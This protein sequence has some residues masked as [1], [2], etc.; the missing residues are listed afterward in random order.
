MPTGFDAFSNSWS[1]GTSSPY[2]RA[3]IGFIFSSFILNTPV[4][5][6]VSLI[7]L[8]NLGQ[9]ID[10]AAGAISK[11]GDGI[12]HLIALGDKGYNVVEARI[13]HNRLVN[14]DAKLFYII[15]Y[16]ERII[17]SLREYAEESRRH[18]NG[19]DRTYELEEELQHDWPLVLT[20]L[21]DILDQTRDLL[22]RVRVERSDF[23]LEPAYGEMLSALST[24]VGLLDKLIREGPP[25]SKEQVDELDIVCDK[26]E[27]LREATAGATAQMSAYIKSIGQQ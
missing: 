3:A 22:E 21:R 17:S 27:K 15:G 9:A 8:K 13:T 12:S 24:K 18:L 19:S 5:A 26:L 4:K 16:N 11:I 7:D 2:A 10:E 20:N 6:D 23:V 25:I 1:W 14:I